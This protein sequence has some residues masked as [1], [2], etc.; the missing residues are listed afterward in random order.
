MSAQQTHDSSQPSGSN[1]NNLGVAQENI[2]NR[3][4]EVQA[5]FSTMCAIEYL[6]STDVDPDMISRILR[7]NLNDEANSRR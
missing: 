5:N 6:K 2:A 7:Q 4:L 3:A 1:L